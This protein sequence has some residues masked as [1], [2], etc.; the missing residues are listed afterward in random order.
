M[1]EQ[2]HN[3]NKSKA[4][5][6]LVLEGHEW[7][8]SAQSSPR[9]QHRLTQ[10]ITGVLNYTEDEM[11]KSTQTVTV[12]SQDRQNQT[13]Q[14]KAFLS[15]GARDH[16]V[17]TEKIPT[18]HQKEQLSNSLRGRLSYRSVESELNKCENQKG[19][20]KVVVVP[21]R[22]LHMKEY[23]TA[24]SGRTSFIEDFALS[25]LQTN[26]TQNNLDFTDRTQIDSSD[27]ARYKRPITTPLDQI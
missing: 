1:R 16:L 25:E 26:R 21:G 8:N 4:S 14:L 9:K 5:Y 24:N 3:L 11:C 23:A 22:R 19:V 13:S 7:Q 18:K 10:S 6:E 12:E 15:S 27:L 17:I 2:L 20:N